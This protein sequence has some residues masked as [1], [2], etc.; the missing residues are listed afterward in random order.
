MDF[1][2][3]DDA[4]GGRPYDIVIYGATGYT[5]SLLVEHLDHLI[6]LSDATARKWAVAG[7]DTKKLRRI[8]ENCKTS[9]GVV[10]ACDKEGF[11]YLAEMCSVL[12]SAAGP[13]IICGSDIVA[14]CVEKNTHYIDV[15]G[16]LV[17]MKRMIKAYHEKAREKGLMIVQ[18][19]GMMCAPN[20]LS[21]YLLAKKMGALAEFREYVTEVGVGGG[22]GTFFSGYAGYEKMLDFE[23]DVLQ[24]PFS[25]GGERKCGRRPAD[26]DPQKATVDDLFP[27]LH[28]S[29]GH[30]TPCAGRLLRRSCG[31]FDADLEAGQGAEG[32]APVS[33]GSEL[34][35]ISRNV[36]LQE[37]AAKQKA[38]TTREP[39]EIRELIKHAQTM[40]EAVKR[41]QY[42]PP[43]G[44]PTQAARANGSM[45]CF[46]TARSEAGD[47]AHVHFRGPDVYEITAMCAVTGALV[48][49]EELDSLRPRERGGVLTPAY[50]FHGSTYV[51]RLMA[52]PYA[53]LRGRSMVFSVQDGKPVAET[54]EKAIRSADEKNQQIFAAS[55]KGTLEGA[56]AP[57]EMLAAT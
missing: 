22:G 24:N 10:E 14:A 39:R 32:E 8:A 27:K 45:E 26:E 38:Q 6:S 37:G 11:L 41:G 56:W 28:L 48:I 49:I 18:C 46:A 51:E 47:W 4:I 43:G 19:A 35:I 25:L 55:L 31:L 3:L 5:G 33:Y 52:T 9:P 29:G 1:D 7:R 13:Y 36:S 54:M 2:D 50:A 20:D 15:T 17:W 21:L 57:P 40:Q 23:L 34:C 44:G 53:G 16:E 42:A 30:S 12:V